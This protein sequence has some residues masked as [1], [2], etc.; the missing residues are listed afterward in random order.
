MIAPPEPTDYPP[1]HRRAREE[2]LEMLAACL[3]NLAAIRVPGIT[4]VFCASCGEQAIV[5][6]GRHTGKH[7]VAHRANPRCKKE[8]VHIAADTPEE[9]EREFKEATKL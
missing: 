5:R 4:P 3:R 1:A 6:F 2:N 7:I 8:R 9:A